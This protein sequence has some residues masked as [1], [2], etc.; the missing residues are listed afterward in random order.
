[1]SEHALNFMPSEGFRARAKDVV[2]NPFLRQSFRGAMDFLINKRISQFPDTEEL[3]SLRTLG[4]HVRQYNLGKLPELLIRLEANLTRNGIQ[5]HWAETPEEANAI[6][7]GLCHQHAA[8]LMIKGKSMVS[9][10]IELNHAA[11]AAGIGALESDMGEYIVQLAGEK[12][13][14]IIMP[15]IHKTKEEIAKLFHEKVPGIDYT[16][17]VDALIQIGRKVLRQKFLEADIGLSVVN[18]AVADTGTLCLVEN[19]GNGRMCTTAPPVHIAITGIEK[20]VE[21]LEHIPP[22]LSLLTRSA[23]GQNISTYFNMISSP[24]K[25][26]EKDGPEEV[27][28]VLLDNGRSQA[29]SDEQLRKTLQCIRC[30]ACMNHCPV[31]TRIGGHAYGT[32]YPGPIGKIISPHMLGL[33]ATKT[34]ATASSL[35]GACGE[36]CPVKIPIPELLMRLREESFSAPH[37]N[38]AMRGQGAGYSRLMTSIWQGWAAVYRSPALYGLVTWVGS[39]L[40]WLMPSK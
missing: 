30:G 36:V 7:L 27:H 9:E 17:N 29:Y 4:E 21:K 28:L 6:I 35:C 5:V 10:E 23:T 13:S 19:E 16:D 26:G 34:M 18:F 20:I 15:A 2:E 24:R 32:T 22:L 38:P 11:E 40:S 1:M 25:A 12:P 33:E 14:H 3:E 39:R 31:Y 37:E 8:K